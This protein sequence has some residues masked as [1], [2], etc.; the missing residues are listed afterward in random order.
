MHTVVRCQ[1]GRL[2]IRKMKKIKR[3]LGP[4]GSCITRWLMSSE[5]I[6]KYSIL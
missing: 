2:G 1:G 3:K 5:C 6:K 4:A